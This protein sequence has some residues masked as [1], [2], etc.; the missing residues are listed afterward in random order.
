MSSTRQTNRVVITGMGTINSLGWTAQDTM[1]AMA[2]GTDGI[3]ELQNII[4][5]QNMRY[6]RGGQI[7]GYDEKDHWTRMQIAIFDRFT[8]LNILAAREAVEQS[9][10]EFD[11]ELAEEAGIIMGNGSGG[12][13]TWERTYHNYFASDNPKR[14]ANPFIIPRVMGNAPV[15]HI[16]MEH[17]I[18]GP[19]F[20]V[21][22]GCAS[23]N[24]A[25][26]QAFHM[27]KYGMAPVMLTGGSEAILNLSGMKAW[28]GLRVVSPGYCRPFSLG[29]QGIVH[30][31][32]AGVFV[33]EEYE[34]AKSRGA[35]IICEV[36]GAACT[37][38]SSDLVMPE[39]SGLIRSMEKCLKDASIN[40]DQVDYINAHG[41]GTVPNDR[42]EIDAIKQTFGDH[43][44]KLSVSS[45]KSMH[46]HCIGGTGA[47][48][49]LAAIMAV[50]DGIIAPT[51]NYE[52][53]DPEC[54]LD[55][56]PNTAKEKKVNVAISNNFAFG[57][58]NSTIAIRGM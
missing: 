25:M 11:G 44:H 18:K 10:L 22:S 45:T 29:R 52:E 7:K 33:F 50:N 5:I 38:D 31:E 20:T 47:V 58:L 3:S 28:E 54:D 4:E 14:R 23:A 12:A 26:T 6:T 9:G 48:E 37:A 19:S 51:I 43:A 46:G 24:H 57:G 39:V 40:P 56:V 41:T 17:N 34:H 2:E 8:Q 1:K 15:C 32:G 16:S 36:L 53:P 55:V 30:G 49:L 21:T 42:T 35:N 13:E 27:V